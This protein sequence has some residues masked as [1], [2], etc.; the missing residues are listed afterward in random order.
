MAPA[1]EGGAEVPFEHRE[2]RLD[3]RPVP[4]DLG[5]SSVFVRALHQP[6]VLVLRQGPRVLGRAAVVGRDGRAD[7]V[8]L[9]HQFVVGGES[10]PASRTMAAI[11][12]HAGTWA[13]TPASW[14][15]SG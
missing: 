4:V 11:A 6:P 15:T 8:V 3:L 12:T 14:S 9:A 1:A 13:R 2:D 10:N 7:P 5:A